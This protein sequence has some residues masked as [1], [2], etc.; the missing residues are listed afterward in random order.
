M[1][2][3][4]VFMVVLA[5]TLLIVIMSSGFS[6]RVY[7]SNLRNPKDKYNMF[8]KQEGYSFVKGMAKLG[9]IPDVTPKTWSFVEEVNE[10]IRN[11]RN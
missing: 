5:L 9:N 10:H 6:I 11:C 7:L 3:L 4:V 1:I 2:E 8:K